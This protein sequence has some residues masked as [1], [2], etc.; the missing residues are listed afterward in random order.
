MIVALPVVVSMSMPMS[1]PMPMPMPMPLIVAMARLTG[2]GGEAKLAHFAVHG[3]LAQVG[4]DFAIAQNLHQLRVTAHL[5]QVAHQLPRVQVLLLLGN[6]Q[7]FLHQHPGKEK[8]GQHNNALRLVQSGAAKALLEAGV[9][10]ADKANFY[11][12]VAAALPHNAGQLVHIAIGIGVTGPPAHKQQHRVF[13]GNAVGVKPGRIQLGQA[14][15][16]EL[17]DGGGN[18]KVTA[19]VEGHLGMALA[20]AI[21]FIGD[22]KFV[23]A[24]RKQQNR[25]HRNV[26]VALLHASIYPVLNG[27]LGQL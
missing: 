18:A 26:G 5:R 7:D 1:M 4:F 19:I 23:V 8:V 12:F 16:P 24:G 3:H 15:L 9:G 2:P 13:A 6:L 17:N 14:F 10:N 27:G 25:Q 21:E 22:I 20:G 11:G